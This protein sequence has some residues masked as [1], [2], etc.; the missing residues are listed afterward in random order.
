MMKLAIF[1]VKSLESF[2][3]RNVPYS[4]GH[5]HVHLST[6][7]DVSHNLNISVRLVLLDISHHF[8]YLQTFTLIL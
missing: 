7:G 6:K 2:L 3:V 8:I 1:V 4:D 5:R